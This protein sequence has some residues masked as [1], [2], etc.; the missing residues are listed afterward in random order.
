MSIWPALTMRWFGVSQAWAIRTLTDS[1]ARCFK[2]GPVKMRIKRLENDSSRQATY[3]KWKNGLI[4]K[5]KTYRLYVTLTLS[6]S[7]FHPVASLHYIMDRTGVL[8]VCSSVL[9]VYVIITFISA[10]SPFAMVEE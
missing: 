1:L 9:P 6:F 3:S 4:K 5:A 2:M 7:C 10:P 8:L